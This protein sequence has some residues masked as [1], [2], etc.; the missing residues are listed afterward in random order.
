MRRATR[1]TL[2]GAAR[3]PVT[4]SYFARNGTARSGEQ[5]P[6]YVI[7]FDLYNNG[8][9]RALSLDYNKFIVAGKLASLKIKR[10][11]PCH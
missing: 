2:A 10:T 4:I 3:W 8:I 9:S 11:K 6:N 1:K 7:G 5:M